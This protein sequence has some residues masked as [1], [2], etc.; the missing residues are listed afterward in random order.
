MLDRNLVDLHAPVDIS[1]ARLEA[2]PE[3][4]RYSA[5]LQIFVGAGELGTA[6][7]E[8][9][10]PFVAMLRTMEVGP[11]TILKGLHRAGFNV[12][13]SE[14]VFNQARDRRYLAALDQ[15]WYQYFLGPDVSSVLLPTRCG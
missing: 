5:G 1:V 3:F 9:T 6:L 7:A 2:T 8:A 12:G 13:P 11:A 15:L 4:R 10:P 14:S